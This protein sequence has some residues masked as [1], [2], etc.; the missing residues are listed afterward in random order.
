MLTTVFAGQNEKN[1]NVISSSSQNC[2]ITY[3][4]DRYSL[5]SMI[6]NNITYHTIQ[7]DE[8]NYPEDSGYPMIPYRVFIF[9]IPQDGS[10]NVTVESSEF[11]EIKDRRIPPVPAFIKSDGISSEIY[12]EG[13]FYK[14][15]EFLPGNL[16]T[17]E[18]PSMIGDQ[19][20]IYV[21]V[22][23]VQ[24]NPSTNTIRKYTKMIIRVDF[25]GTVGVKEH[26]QKSKNEIIYKNILIN[27][28]VAKQWR[29][30]Q[31]SK[32]QRKIPKKHLIGE[33][34][35]IP[36]RSSQEGIFKIT[37]SFL[38]SHG[39]DIDTIDPSTLKIYN[40]GGQILPQS[41][42]VD[43][44]DSLIEN[45]ILAS[46]TEDNLFDESDYILFYGKGVT[47]WNYN[48]KENTYNHYINP[49][50]EHNIYWL[51]FNDGK[52][53]KRIESTSSLP[54]T[55]GE[56]ISK[57]H[58][59]YFLE[60]DINNPINRGSLWYGHSFSVQE[61]YRSYVLPL[62]DIIPGDTL[63]FHFIFRSISDGNHQFAVELNSQLTEIIQF[64]GHGRFS[65]RFDIV[66]G[67]SDQNV[68]TLQY[69]GSGSGSIYLDWFEIEYIREL[70]SNKDGLIFYS[71][72]TQGI[73]NYVLSDFKEEPLVLDITDITR[74][75]QLELK[76]ESGGWQ[77]M[78]SV[79]T[80]S[81]K[82]YIAVRTSDYLTPGSIEKDESSDLRNSENQGD[83]LIITHEDFYD[84]AERLKISKE[85]NDSLTVFI[86]KIQDV[87]DEFSWGLF[88]PTAIRDF[89]KAAYE[90]W[91]IRPSYLL[92]FGD[93]D[94]DYRNITSDNDKNW[95]PPFERRDNDKN[96]IPPFERSGL[97]H[98]AS[99][100][101]DD[102]YVYVSGDDNKTD[103]AVGR[104][105]VQT[106][107]EA[108]TVVDKIIQYETEPL[109]GDW[110]SVIIMVGDDEISAIRDTETTH[111]IAAE[112]IA[113]RIIP[114]LLNVEKIYLTEYPSEIKA[115]GTRKPKAQDDL[116]D[117]FNRQNFRFFM[118]QH[119]SLRGT[120]MR[121]SRVLRKTFSHLKIKAALLLSLLPGNA[122][123]QV[124]KRSTRLFSISCSREL[125]QQNEL[126]MHYGQLN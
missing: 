71:P 98:I 26:P 28:S 53:G 78:D 112:Y 42:A 15:S 89:V 93:G 14:K 8:A 87:Y 30:R 115:E 52:T 86:A 109:F 61:S 34:Y 31:E 83:L 2:I 4:P 75:H 99:R 50:T 72:L 24:F 119:A 18:K 110:R 80:S 64:K 118:L 73:Y 92:L 57:F 9:G 37:G 68:L 114:P 79:K 69:S 46:G 125:A 13:E 95:I 48:S 82:K 116:I 59:H 7:I 19:R 120:T 117:R 56:Q 88:D 76:S 122:M 62:T 10:A 77:F 29:K 49:Y 17:V 20:V 27:Y 36:V 3:S 41:I 67:S 63:R 124:M 23:P 58:D 100:A 43:R 47:G 32:Y 1:I 55:G 126:G 51:A 97:D 70:K 123:L 96:W 102:W 22:Y 91:A 81:P 54:E 121:L 74:N 44:P 38:K 60:Q 16:F 90:T 6:V 66:G 111:I 85:A 94:Y 113:T 108:S 84:Q 11:I 25:K 5:S 45:P 33:M 65:E 105:T 104:L 107:F 39:I 106:E 21:S 103:L 12:T 101:T 40:N 35:K